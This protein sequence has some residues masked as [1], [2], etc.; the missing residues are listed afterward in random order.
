M[1]AAIASRSV[2]KVDIAVLTVAKDLWARKGH[3]R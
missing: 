3:A 2:G 1:E